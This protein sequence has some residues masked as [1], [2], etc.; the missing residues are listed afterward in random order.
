[1]L[2]NAF[3]VDPGLPERTLELQVG[4]LFGLGVQADLLVVSAFQGVYEPVAGTL[5]A[6][7]QEACGLE[8]GSLPVALDLRQSRLGCWVSEPLAQCCPRMRWPDGSRTRFQR[9]AVV[10]SL[11]ADPKAAQPKTWPVFNQ[12][13]CLLALLPLHGIASATVAT[14]LLATGN[15]GIAPQLLFPALLERC[16]DGFRHIPDLERLV[17]FDREL[18]PLEQLAA[19]IDGE[20]NRPETQRKLIVL[21][22]DFL[23]PEA[24]VDLLLSFSGRHQQLKLDGDIQ[25]LHHQLSNTQTTAV[26]LGIHSRR[27]VERLVR[28]RLGWRYGTLNEGILE[29]RRHNLHPWII[30]CLHQVRVFGNMVSHPGKPGQQRDV[31]VADVVA[32][33]A[34]LQRVLADYPW[35]S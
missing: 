22:E 24:L 30:S 28:Q 7:L 19:L 1:M 18:G 3:D 32:M 29:L 21:Q 16:R 17:L 6:R 31:H 14:P 9:L 2:L 15:Q 12:L 8:V 10:E 11:P 20:L 35:S 5:I 23:P 4:E 13:F 34:A 33:L 26:A 25:E 27:L